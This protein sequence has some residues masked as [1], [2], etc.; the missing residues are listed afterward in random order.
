LRVRDLMTPDPVTVPADYTLARFLDQVAWQR[1]H[2]AYPV[3]ENEKP[4]GLLA[5]RCVA[6]VPRAE[7]ETHSVR[8][9]MLPD[10]DV[11][12]LNA[13]EPGVDA[14]AELGDRD[15]SRGLVLDDGRL[16]GILS[17][18]DIARALE[19]RPPLRPRT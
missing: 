15:S 16:V 10:D 8:E 19:A 18:A 1:R 14:R 12:T 17:V 6:A 7:W 2:T 11:P 9:C 13:D 4:L 3:V 5:F